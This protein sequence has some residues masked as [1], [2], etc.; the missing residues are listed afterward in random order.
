[1]S[2]HLTRDL[3]N[4]HRDVMTMSVMVEEL[5][6]RAVEQLTSP[7]L[8]SAKLLAEEDDQIDQWD[9]RIEETCLK[10]LA[11]HQPV[12]GD[13]RR[14]A[15]VLKI[16]NELER[17]ADLGVDMAERAIGLMKGPVITIPETLPE[18]MRIAVKMLNQ[19][20]DA[21]VRLDSDLARD[22]FATDHHVDSL[23]SQIIAQL[24]G[25]MRAQHD[26]VE[27]AL[28]LFSATRHIE[29]IADHATNIAEDVIYLV[30]GAIVR[31]Q[32]QVMS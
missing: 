11:L 14:I 22:V 2:T 26:F 13:L 31:H 20:I 24:L 5:V 10:I 15:T 25:V 30:E 16:S 28:H 21:Y 23:Q 29:R 4:L 1:M 17:V 9:V 7:D 32:H 18:M 12:A 27:P 8:D 19:S 6:K 3:D